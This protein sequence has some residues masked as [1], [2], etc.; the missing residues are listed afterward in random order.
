M[1]V[2]CKPIGFKGKAGFELNRHRIEI[3][4]K[5]KDTDALREC[6]EKQCAG[7]T[8][9]HKI[10]GLTTEESLVLSL[11]QHYSSCYWLKSLDYAS[12]AVMKG[13][14]WLDESTW[15]KFRATIDCHQQSKSITIQEVVKVLKKFQLFW[16]QQHP[17]SYESEI[18]CYGFYE[19]SLN[20]SRQTF[21][22]PENPAT[23]S[24]PHPTHY[25]WYDKNEKCFDAITCLSNFYQDTASYW[26]FLMLR[27]EICLDHF[28]ER[29][30]VDSSDDEQ[31]RSLQLNDEVKSLGITFDSFKRQYTRWKMGDEF[32]HLVLDMDHCIQWPDDDSKDSASAW[33]EQLWQVTARCWARQTEQAIIDR[34]RKIEMNRRETNSKTNKIQENIERLLHADIGKGRKAKKETDG[35]L[36]LSQLLQDLYN[37]GFVPDYNLA[38]ERKNHDIYK[39]KIASQLALK[40]FAL[41]HP[42]SSANKEKRAAL[43]KYVKNQSNKNKVLK[44]LHSALNNFVG[45]EISDGIT[46]NHILTIQ[47]EASIVLKKIASSVQLDGLQKIVINAQRVI[48][49]DCDWKVPGISVTLSAPLIRILCSSG[50]EKHTITTSGCDGKEHKSLKAADG[51]GAGAS[52]S[53]G[54]A[55]QDGEDAGNVKIDCQSFIGRLKIVAHGGKGADGQNGGDGQPGHK[56]SDGADGIFPSEQAEGST[57][58]FFGTRLYESEGWP[59][60]RGGDGGSGGNCGKGGRGGRGGQLY[61]VSSHHDRPTDLSQFIE[62]D[63]ADGQDGKDGQPGRGAPGGTGGKDGQDAFLYF[64][65]DNSWSLKG[66]WRRHK[67]SRTDLEKVC[68]LNLNIIML[69]YKIREEN[70]PMRYEAAEGKRGNEGKI[71]VADHLQQRDRSSNATADVVA[72]QLDNF[73]QSGSDERERHLEATRRD[74]W[75]ETDAESINRIIEERKTISRHKETLEVLNQQLKRLDEIGLRVRSK[76]QETLEQRITQQAVVSQRITRQQKLNDDLVG[77]GASGSV[78]TDPGRDIRSAH[79]VSDQPTAAIQCLAKLNA[80]ISSLMM[81]KDDNN[82]N[83]LPIL[84]TVQS[85]VLNLSL[86]DHEKE[87]NSIEKIFNEMSSDPLKLADSLKFIGSN[88]R[89]IISLA[90]Q[91]PATDLI[92]NLEEY[93]ASTGRDREAAT[94][95]TICVLH[96]F[97]QHPIK[98]ED[99]INLLTRPSDSDWT[100]Q[101][102]IRLGLFFDK[103]L[104]SVIS[105]TILEVYD[106]EE[107]GTSRASLFAEVWLQ[108]SP[109]SKW[110]RSAPSSDDVNEWLKGVYF[111]LNQFQCSISSRDKKNNILLQFARDRLGII[112]NV[113]EI[114][115]EKRWKLFFVVDHFQP[116]VDEMDAIGQWARK[117]SDQQ[118]MAYVERAFNERFIAP[119][120]SQ[121]QS[122]IENLNWTKD[123]KSGKIDDDVEKAIR[124]LKTASVSSFTSFSFG[125]RLDLSRAVKEKL[126]I[127]ERNQGSDVEKRKFLDWIKENSEKA[128]ASTA[129]LFVSSQSDCDDQA[130]IILSLLADSKKFEKKKVMLELHFRLSYLTDASFEPRQIVK[131]A[132][133]LLNESSDHPV[134]DEFNNYHWQCFRSIFLENWSNYFFSH[135]SKCH[136]QTERFRDRV[137]DRNPEDDDRSLNSLELALERYLLF[138]TGLP[139]LDAVEKWRQLQELSSLKKRTEFIA[140]DLKGAIQEIES[141]IITPRINQLYSNTFLNITN[142]EMNANTNIVTLTDIL[143]EIISRTTKSFFDDAESVRSLLDVIKAVQ[144]IMDLT[145]DD[146]NQ[147]KASNSGVVSSTKIREWKKE[148][149]RWKV[150]DGEAESMVHFAVEELVETAEWKF[151]NGDDCSRKIYDRLAARR[152][153]MLHT[154]DQELSWLQTFVGYLADSRS[155]IDMF[156]VI[157]ATIASSQFLNWNK[158]KSGKTSRVQVVTNIST[159]C[160]FIPK[161]DKI[162]WNSYFGALLNLKI[163][164]KLIWLITTLANFVGGQ[165]SNDRKRATWTEVKCWFDGLESLISDTKKMNGTSPAVN[166]NHW[167]EMVRIQQVL[168]DHCRACYE[169]KLLTDHEKRSKNKM[170]LTLVCFTFEN[171]VGRLTNVVRFVRSKKEVSSSRQQDSQTEFLM[172]QLETRQLLLKAL[173]QLGQSD[174]F[175]WDEE[176]VNRFLKDLLLFPELKPS[177]YELCILSNMLVSGPRKAVIERWIS[178]ESCWEPER[179]RVLVKSLQDKNLS[180]ND[181]QLLFSIAGYDIFNDE[182]KSYIKLIDDNAAVESFL[183]V[184]DQHPSYFLGVLQ[185]LAIER[186]RAEFVRCFE[187]SITV[188]D[189]DRYLPKPSKD[190]ALYRQGA[191]LADKQHITQLCRSFNRLIRTKNEQGD[192][193]RDWLHWIRDVVV[194]SLKSYKIEQGLSVQQITKF[195]KDVEEFPLDLCRSVT[196]RSR[197]HQWIDMLAIFAIKELFDQLIE[198]CREDRIKM[199]SSDIVQQ[200]VQWWTSSGA[201][202]SFLHIFH[203]KIRKEMAGDPHQ[204]MTL[205][206]ELTKKLTALKLH[207]LLHE[208]VILGRFSTASLNDWPS[209][210]RYVQLAVDWTPDLALRL[211]SV[212]DD[213]F[214]QERTD[215]FLRLV[216]HR[217]PELNEKSDDDKTQLRNIL[218][219]LL[220]YPWM[221]DRWIDLIDKSLQQNSVI[222]E[223][224]IWNS[225]SDSEMIKTEMSKSS[226]VDLSVDDILTIMSQDPESSKV[227]GNSSEMAQRITLIRQEAKN[228]N[229]RQWPE[230]IKKSDKTLKVDEFLA[231]ACR[232]VYDKKGYVPRDVQLIAVVAFVSSDDPQ[233]GRMPRRM[234]QISTGEGKTL[235][236][237]LV[238][239]YHVLRHWEEDRHVNII[240]S[241]P[242]LAEA[243][244]AEIGWLF[245]AFGVSVSNNCDQK[246]SN[247][248]DIRRERYNNDVIYGD[249]G[250]FMRDILLTRFF[251]DKD[252]TRNRN[253][254]A[255]IVDE[256]DSLTLDKGENVLYLSHNIPEMY[257]LMGLFVHIWTTVNAPDV[258]RLAESSDIVDEIRQLI[259]PMIPTCV[260]NGMKKFAEQH[261]STWIRSA[262]RA[263][264]LLQPNDAYKVDD[265]GDGQGRRIVIMDKETGVEQTQSEWSDGLQQFLQ[266]KHGMKWT[267]ISLKAIFMSNIGYFSEF[268]GRM[269]GLTGTLGSTAECDLLRQVFGVNFFRLPR[270]RQR[271]CIQHEPVIANSRQAWVD[272]MQKVVVSIASTTSNP[273]QQ[274]AVLV[275]CENIES[276]ELIYERLK[277]TIT[278]AQIQVIKYVSSFDESFKNHQEILPG[279]VIIATNLAGRGTDLKPSQSLVDNGGLHL[280]IGFVPPNAR[281][282]A[283]AEGRTARAGQPGSFQLVIESVK[284]ENHGD[285]YGRM[286]ELKSKRDDYERLRLDNIRQESLPKIQLE[287]KLFH[288]FY[289]KCVAPLG[290]TKSHLHLQQQHRKIKRSCLNNRWALWLDENSGLI[291]K[292]HHDPKVMAKLKG[293]FKLLTN[294]VQSSDVESIV[295]SPSELMMFARHNE[296]SSLPDKAVECY[297]RVASMEP[298]WCENALLDRARLVLADS[299]NFKK[300]KEA[301]GYCKRARQLIDDRVQVLAS[302]HQQVDQCLN[303]QMERGSALCHKRFEEQINNQIRL[304]RIH[305]S[306]IDNLLGVPLKRALA[307]FLPTENNQ[308]IDQVIELLGQCDF[309]K[310]LRYSKKAEKSSFDWPPFVAHCREPLSD[311]VKKR[312]CKLSDF[313]DAIGQA[314]TKLWTSLI[315]VYIDDG[316]LAGGGKMIQAHQDVEEIPDVI[317][318]KSYRRI[319]PGWLKFHD[320][321][322]FSLISSTLGIDDDDQLKKLENWLEDKKV[323]QE[324]D[325]CFRH[326]LLKQI[327][328]MDQDPDAQLVEGVAIS[329]CADV[330]AAWFSSPIVEKDGNLYVLRPLFDERKKQLAKQFLDYLIDVGVVKDPAIRF[331]S[332]G[333]ERSREQIKEDLDKIKSGID[334]LYGLNQLTKLFYDT[335]EKV[336]E[337]KEDVKAISTLEQSIKGLIP[338]IVTP[339]VVSVANQASTLSSGFNSNTR[340]SKK[341]NALNEMEEK[342]STE[343]MQA[344]DIHLG[345]LKTLAQVKSSFCS[346]HAALPSPGDDP[347]SPT[348]EVHQFNN[349]HLDRVLKVDEHVSRWDWRVG[350]VALIG[351]AQLYGAIDFPFYREGLVDEGINDL[352]FAFQCLQS[353]G[354]FSLKSYLV[355]KGKSL[356]LTAV[357]MGLGAARL[358]KACG[359]NLKQANKMIVQFGVTLIEWFEARSY[360][361]LQY[362]NIIS[363]SIIGLGVSRFLTWLNKFIMEQ[364]LERIKSFLLNNPIFR[365][366]FAQLKGSMKSLMIAIV[367]SGKSASEASQMIR[368]VL[369]R[370]KNQL[371]NGDWFTEL[372]TNVSSVTS[373]MKRIFSDS[374]AGLSNLQSSYVSE[375]RPHASIGNSQVVEKVIKVSQTIIDYG[376]KAIEVTQKVEKFATTCQTVTKLA[377]HGMTYVGDLNAALQDELRALRIKSQQEQQRLLTTGESGGGPIGLA[378]PLNTTQ[379]REIRFEYRL[380][381]RPKI[382]HFPVTRR[383]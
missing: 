41:L 240:T 125:Q 118:M 28:F 19:S 134:T 259:E 352:M 193:L 266:L 170:N 73:H 306:K 276:A 265:C 18:I 247:D 95:N 26:D 287:E 216:V 174:S 212:F 10:G 13:F 340:Q 218:N 283:Q 209:V 376:Q 347:S 153:H 230:Q 45:R 199:K 263:C 286:L 290:E 117:N 373:R 349:Q 152:R 348:D 382:F 366:A 8:S 282:E 370:A 205:V 103:W 183:L 98:F 288:E 163:S 94:K 3:D 378:P 51:N 229:V 61:F 115:V 64:K 196:T 175:Y 367:K 256:V 166:V 56:G 5:E 155:G 120:W 351:V 138:T 129:E 339:L 42:P 293:N 319:L 328:S 6:L 22:V 137:A 221:K 227:I 299:A 241:S 333:T 104:L 338:P 7:L 337:K 181:A 294:S 30:F 311:L 123:P 202:T 320:G 142:K 214:G 269:Y 198:K 239:I 108:C 309:M 93:L 159:A 344:I 122:L 305:S 194:P 278:S 195:F 280:I 360:L 298:N 377:T 127:F 141:T 87:W 99:V 46:R 242:V 12:L 201:P 356:A 77:L 353:P 257:D 343:L 52:G 79:P 332:A 162:S 88:L 145:N 322:D 235:I 308:H 15:N 237:A 284:D 342:L 232:V 25:L 223:Q 208:D 330:V 111:F 261:L 231:V 381:T 157:E 336:K 178:L 146:L 211:K 226:R 220:R 250:S 200:L 186:I 252:V 185:K 362:S 258:V 279:Q 207:S 346:L 14:E 380:Q 23:S 359:G 317:I 206:Q 215:Q 171:T 210:I 62:R 11:L 131:I 372:C 161:P 176:T 132:D 244:I 224:S 177:P 285:P 187:P 143:F 84:R 80:W 327:P 92:K 53:H 268:E 1:A 262:F 140:K 375:Y 158:L 119:L 238:A 29:E 182:E 180:L 31:S 78:T 60:S 363:S 184:D 36:A 160:N 179:I 24:S 35:E 301:K 204:L 63:C 304:W 130:E 68:L 383:S 43:E 126:E 295:S 49:V 106:D 114:N 274:R 144:W 74:E 192:E 169:T 355:D 341:A 128:E 96:E 365:P 277:T 267:P 82:K 97:Y 245:Q 273:N 374:T 165:L 50:V 89:L 34:R 38:C 121:I 105:K 67:G 59:G 236:S 243:N 65:P 191:L 246:C 81:S 150:I 331:P 291:E 307:N 357:T 233:A 172:D 222:V 113:S 85:L 371:N 219:T 368:Q 270:F 325:K 197:P 334:S 37:P 135:W 40:V 203:H 102:D 47:G 58:H 20:L 167:K 2:K 234:G 253:P 251:E 316:K 66:Q 310:P 154:F 101:S 213:Q 364:V 116:K 188:Q 217:H 248:D 272:Q 189:M 225:L 124:R 335:D 260:P 358:V 147:K 90:D 27:A 91:S 314:E 76:I 296:E 369:D 148:M 313:E 4:I 249:L 21:Y 254:G 32:D 326:R 324:A 112:R 321:Q 109:L 354:S 361:R 149:V 312:N 72:S 289:K 281:V 173:I 17:D 303:R 271:F 228:V 139:P 83:V 300:K 136:Q 48:Y 57:W 100:Q 75:A 255:I 33:C 190:G 329:S 264:Y 107:L 318:P 69:G 71:P 350:A 292:A 44:E 156:K 54:L 379:S 70:F 86:D 323:L 275:V 133:I 297:C 110:T 302:L 39:E 164:E 55:G 9:N 345:Q 315:S 151:S 168:I 16:A